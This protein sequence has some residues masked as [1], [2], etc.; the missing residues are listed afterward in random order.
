M[1]PIIQ[2]LGMTVAILLSSISAPAYD[3]EVDGIYYNIASL[4]ELTC[5]VT[6]GD[7]KYKGDISIPSEVSYKNKTLSVISINA[8]TFKNCTDLTSVTIPNSVTTINHTVFYDCTSLTS[9]II[10]NSVT[11]IGESAFYGCAGLTSVIIPNSVTAIGESAF[12]GCAGLTSVDIPNSVTK[13]YDDTF[14]GCTGLTS[15][16]IPNSITEINRDTFAGCTGLTS[17][18]IPNSVT[19]LNGFSGCT[20]LTSVTIPNSITEIGESAFEG[21]TSLT[22]VT[23]PNSVTWIRYGAFS[24]CTKLA[25]VSIPNSVVQIGKRAFAKCTGLTSLEIP[26]LLNEIITTKDGSFVG[27]SNIKK[28]VILGDEH[29]MDLTLEGWSSSYSSASEWYYCSLFPFSGLNLEELYLGRPVY[30]DYS[31][32][33]N[34]GKNTTKT[35]PKVDTLKKITFGKYRKSINS[36]GIWGY[37]KDIPTTAEIYCE[38]LTPPSINSSNGFTDKHYISNVVYVP[39][40]SLEA[41]KQAEGWKNFWDIRAYDPASGIKD[42]SVDDVRADVFKVYNLAGMLVKETA[43]KTE[44]YDLPAGIYIINGR[45]VAIR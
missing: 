39:K 32:L 33:P 13:L 23:I 12:Y 27:C 4:D 24:D 42:V 38:N 34:S 2:K 35:L 29:V 9:V 1:S 21:C 36:L 26:S 15:V 37:I 41:Y 8:G 31:L 44:A 7:N 14:K 43:D 20:S 25:S 19:Y 18:E 16:T 40:E 28:L 22:S 30:C 11:A 3:F 5:R 10:P 6:S 45:K 17:V